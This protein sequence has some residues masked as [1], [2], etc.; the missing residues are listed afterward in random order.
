MMEEHLFE[1]LARERNITVEE[2][3]VI[4]SARI[5]KG[6]NDPDQEKRAQWRKIPCEGEIPTPDEWLR[7]TVEKLQEEGREDLLQ[8][9][10][11]S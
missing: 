9:Y 2:M 3:R 11:K 10:T 5:E 8:L 1:R 6:W 4:I 7:Y